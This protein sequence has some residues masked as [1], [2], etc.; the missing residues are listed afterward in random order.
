MDA[1]ADKRMCIRVVL[2]AKSFMPLGEYAEA[3]RESGGM[4]AGKSQD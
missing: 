4:V 1:G 3:S 2:L